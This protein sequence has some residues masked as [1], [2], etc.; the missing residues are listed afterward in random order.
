MIAG[1]KFVVFS[2]IGGAVPGDDVNLRL[3][4]ARPSARAAARCVHEGVFM[5]KTVKHTFSTIGDRSGTIART[6]GSETASL[7][8]RLGGGMASLARRIGPRR[9]LIGLAAVAAAIFGSVMLMR[10]LRA[11][12]VD[13][14][15]GTEGAGEEDSAPN[16][17]RSRGQRSAN[18]QPSHRG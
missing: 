4:R 16:D 3:P 9:G 8:N 14:E 15:L 6:F 7:A 11:R 12:K 13:R 10:Y 17:A 18:V 1:K 2:T 5:M